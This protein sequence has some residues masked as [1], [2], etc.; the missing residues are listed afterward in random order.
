MN[1][2]LI[3]KYGA[4]Y[5]GGLRKL[6]VD[7]GMSEPTLHRC[8]R[9]N[10]IQATDLEAIS[11]LLNVEIGVFFIQED[12]M[13][14]SCPEGV[15]RGLSSKDENIKLLK[16]QIELLRRTVEDKEIIIKL[17]KTTKIQIFNDINKND[18][19]IHTIENFIV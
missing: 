13:P 2:Q 9:K 4:S 15:S 11:R 10:K 12:K 7:A 5:P 3:K 18:K 8:I 17:L 19:H 14:S 6:A 16:E 1:L